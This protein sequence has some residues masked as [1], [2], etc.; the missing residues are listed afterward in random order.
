[1]KAAKPV[2]PPSYLEDVPMD[3]ATPRVRR[4]PHQPLR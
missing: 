3:L 4:N 1:M 2:T